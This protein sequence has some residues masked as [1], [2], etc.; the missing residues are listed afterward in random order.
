MKWFTD[1]EI[2][3]FQKLLEHKA[4][5][6]LI[7]S[8]FSDN[9]AAKLKA[10]GVRNLANPFGTV[11]NPGSISRQLKELLSDEAS[12]EAIVNHD[13]V[14]KSLFHHSSFNR[15]SKA[16]LEGEI[17]KSRERAG[18]FIQDADMLIITL[19]SAWVYE[20]SEF[21]LVANCHKIPQEKFSKRLLSIDEIFDELRTS[22]NLCREKNPK[23]RIML[24]ISPVRHLKDGFV[25][26]SRSKA[27]LIESARKLCEEEGLDYF[28][29]YEIQMDV[30]RD[31]RFYEAD[32]LHPSNEAVDFIWDK[33]RNSLFSADAKRLMNDI[34][35]VVLSL[36]HRTQYPESE[37]ARSFAKKLAIKTQ[38][39][40]AKIPYLEL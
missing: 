6:V 38:E 29:S 18:A 34:N 15:T 23:I 2:P 36:G 4:K 17:S 12:N 28:P 35:R 21:G 22:I 8:C 5:L 33:F 37:A 39:L 3:P 16:E 11:Y 20:H 13:G 31:Y 25:E 27:V 32:M 26:N 19:G 24:N 9:I 1:I 14:F 40:K 7:G 30:L 10:H